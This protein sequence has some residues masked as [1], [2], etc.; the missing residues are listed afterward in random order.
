MKT[1][2]PD[3]ALYCPSHFGNTYECV[4]DPEM[5]DRLTEAKFWGF[6]RFMD[7]FDTI[8]LYDV[9]APGR[10][11]FNLPEAMWDRKFRNYQVAD[12][13]GYELGLSVTPNHVF[14]DQVTP[15]NQATLT[16]HI[17]G[18]LVCPSRPGVVERILENYR[19]LFADFARRGLRLTSLLACAYD[20]GGCACEACQPWIATFGKLFRQIVDLA[21]GTFGPMKA[22]LL[23]WWWSDDDHRHF[24]DW[25]NR[26]AAGAFDAMVFHLPYGQSA[27]QPR[28]IP[29]GCAR[30]SFVHIS[31]GEKTRGDAYCHYGANIAPQRIE[32]TVAHLAAEKAA[33]FV[34]Y[35]EGD[36]DDIN[37]ALLAGMASGQ[38]DDASQVLQAYADRYFGTDPEGWVTL[39]GGM[40]H[41]ETID[42]G[43][44]RPLFDRLA[45]R[46]KPGWRLAQVAERLNMAEAHQAVL[47]E[48]DWT[49]S[50]L[51]AADRFLEAK[52]RLYRDVWRLGLQ[53]HICRF[54][55]L[56][57]AWYEQYARQRKMAAAAPVAEMPPEA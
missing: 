31:Y 33:G 30:K 41:F 25:A 28:P 15:E 3:R 48:T 44:A 26:H 57:P 56:M 12:D 9:Y 45:A 8:D 7:W 18:Q 43:T 20:Y 35:S 53:R 42:V 38:Y 6:N 11:L 51:A 32:R 13:L 27:Y 24:A 29:R 55:T 17:F 39:L 19:Q 40:G 47:R 54:D 50:R 16:D 37:K 4:L 36:H 49:P 14:A 22:E 34:A 52:A 2:L 21:K 5:R 1:I 10:R 23:G 46:A